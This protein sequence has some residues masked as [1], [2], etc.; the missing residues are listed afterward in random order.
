MERRKGTRT[1]TGRTKPTD[2][3]KKAHWTKWF[4][5]REKNNEK[6]M[7]KKEADVGEKKRKSEAQWVIFIERETND[8]RMPWS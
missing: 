1:H 2:G 3:V 7:K 8:R 5:E 4:V 6:R